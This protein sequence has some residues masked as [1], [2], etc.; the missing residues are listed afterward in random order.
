MAIELVENHGLKQDQ[1]AEMLGM[2]QSAVSKY[3]RKTRGYVI[4][5]DGITEVEPLITKMVT[6]LIDGKYQRTEYLTIFCRACKTVQKTGLMCQ[7]CKKAD[8]N[9]RI[10]ECDF[11]L[12]YDPC[13]RRRRKRT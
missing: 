9:G 6:L 8:I 11:C 2:S 4:R 13:E 7:F 1:A 12:S 3:T 10:R 5:I